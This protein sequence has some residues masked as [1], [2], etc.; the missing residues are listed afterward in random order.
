MTQASSFPI[1]YT[2]SVLNKNPGISD[3]YRS[4]GGTLSALS[5]HYSLKPVGT[6]E[7][8]NLQRWIEKE[9]IT[10]LYENSK[11]NKILVTESRDVVGDFRT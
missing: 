4:D 11:D 9:V 7:D 6:S 5:I 10:A 1:A 3:A 2:E 8:P